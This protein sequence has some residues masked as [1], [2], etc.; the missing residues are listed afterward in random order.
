ML[1]IV[2]VRHIYCEIHTQV[3]ELRDLHS[4]ILTVGRFTFGHMCC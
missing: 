2:T 3:Y 1:E 4:G